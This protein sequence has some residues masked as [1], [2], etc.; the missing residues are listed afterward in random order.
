MEVEA[1][2]EEIPDKAFQIQGRISSSYSQNWK[3]KIRD[4]INYFRH[5]SEEELLTQTGYLIGVKSENEPLSGTGPDRRLFDK[6]LHS[7]LRKANVMPPKP[8]YYQTVKKKHKKR[9]K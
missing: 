5:F 3:P 2:M 9:E 1:K 8:R 6:S 7:T 4:C